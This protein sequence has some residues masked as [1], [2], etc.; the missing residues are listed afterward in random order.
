MHTNVNF[1][2]TYWVTLTDYDFI[3]EYIG[4]FQSNNVQLFEWIAQ[5]RLKTDKS[6]KIAKISD[7]FSNFGAKLVLY[8]VFLL[9]QLHA[10][11]LSILAV[12]NL[13]IV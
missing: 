8:K 13:C 2:S 5:K 1:S 6:I 9:H 12:P 10:S 4:L 7:S 11:N 3:D